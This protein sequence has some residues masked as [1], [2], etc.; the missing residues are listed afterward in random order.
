MFVGNSDPRPIIRNLVKMLKPGGYLQWEELD[1]PDSH[2]KCSIECCR[3]QR[4][5]SFETR[6]VP[7]A[8]FIR[9][10]ELKIIRARSL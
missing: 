8:T 9:N 4:S 5:S 3:R 6:F 10:G 2:V 1:F 7:E